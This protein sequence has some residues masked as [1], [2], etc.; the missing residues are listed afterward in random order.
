MSKIYFA[1]VNINEQIYKVYNDEISLD[2]LLSDVYRNIE[3]Q[4][5]LSDKEFDSYIKAIEEKEIKDVDFDQQE[6]SNPELSNTGRYKFFDISKSNTAEKIISGR[7]GY[8]KPGTHSSY[9]PE[10]DTVIEEFDENKID[11]ITFYF[12]VDNEI[13]AFTNSRGLRNNR[14][15]R[16][17]SALIRKAT[18]IGLELYLEKNVIDFKKGVGEVDTLK[19]IEVDLIPPN[20][21]DEEFE[22]LFNVTG[23]RVKESEAEE[24]KQ[25]YS[26]KK[27]KGLNKRSKLVQKI[28]IGVGLSYAN[29][30]F[31][32]FD[33][34]DEIIS[35]DSR[36]KFP[37]TK[38]VRSKDSK[39]KIIIS[40]KA[41]QGIT[42]ILRKRQ[43]LRNNGE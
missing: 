26:T 42:D 36:K 28:I 16:V 12:D 30:K 27:K 33:K 43:E 35:V 4:T 23:E 1:K 38:E 10:E 34:Q 14:I 31:S 19:K 3:N 21:N 6:L 32:G 18:G 41:E 17:I 11:Y 37:Y 13:I 25:Q 9:D 5:I 29:A 40:R 15:L 24:I 2:S 7:L 22:D 8:I 20:N 39:D